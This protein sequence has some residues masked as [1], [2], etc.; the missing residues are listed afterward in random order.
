MVNG[1]RENFIRV[2]STLLPEHKRLF[3]QWAA[4]RYYL[5]PMELE[6]V[7]IRDLPHSAAL[8]AKKA[9]VMSVT[10]IEDPEE[11]GKIPEPMANAISM[12]KIDMPVVI[13]EI[14]ARCLTNAVLKTRDVLPEAQDKFGN[15]IEQFKLFDMRGDINNALRSQLLR[16]R[17][18][19]VVPEKFSNHFIKAVKSTSFGVIVGLMF[20]TLLS[21]FF[22]TSKK[23]VFQSY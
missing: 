18:I 15:I 1:T 16:E 12:M 4:L 8:L 19:Q 21:V 22:K 13:R 10:T 7:R 3:Q 6:P 5:T 2:A 11:G 20:G 23:L 9:G 17:L 14:D